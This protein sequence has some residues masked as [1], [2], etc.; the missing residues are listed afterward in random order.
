M[1]IA[2]Q[3]CLWFLYRP[4]I[5][6]EPGAASNR[7]RGPRSGRAMDFSAVEESDGLRCVS[8]LLLSGFGGADHWG[9][10]RLVRPAAPWDRWMARGR[11]R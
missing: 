11:W 9:G 6:C 10:V 7:G 3:P 4:L 5:V 1:E 8:E 2:F